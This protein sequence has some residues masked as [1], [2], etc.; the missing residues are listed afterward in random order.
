MHKLL[1]ISVAA[2]NVSA[3]IRQ[4]LDSFVASSFI[5]LFEII[6]VNDGSKMIPYQLYKN[7]L[8]TIQIP[9]V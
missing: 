4:C 6:V 9:F 3:T 8:E 7:M 1:S 2:Y 5:D